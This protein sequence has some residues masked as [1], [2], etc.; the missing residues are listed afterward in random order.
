MRI[1]ISLI[2]LVVLVLAAVASA[3]TKI[4]GTTVC[5]KPDQQHMI[6]VGDRA[7]HSLTVSQGKCSWSKPMEIAGIQTKDD[8][9]SVAGD[10][11][12]NKSNGRGYVVG[13]MANG[14][15]FF[16]RLRGTSTL[17]DGAIETDEGKFTFAGGTGKLK[18]IKGGGTYKGK[19]GPEGTT[20]EVEGEYTLPAK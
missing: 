3:Q 7:G 15:K 5:A 2:P 19:G 14:D 11:S 6:E 10:V 20:Y 16:V 1:R 4:S 18:G 13:T 8:Q 9:V 17:K 12:G